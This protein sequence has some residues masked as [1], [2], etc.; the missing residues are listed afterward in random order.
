MSHNGSEDVQPIHTVFKMVTPTV[1]VRL[2]VGLGF[3]AS[4]VGW[5]GTGGCYHARISGKWVWV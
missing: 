3:Q 2:N 4:S 1:D 5:L